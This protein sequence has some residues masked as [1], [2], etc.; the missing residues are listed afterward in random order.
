MSLFTKNLDKAIKIADTDKNEERWITVR[1]SH[2]KIDGQGNPIVGNSKL[3]AAIKGKRINGASEKGVSFENYN[4]E[5]GSILQEV[6]TL[7][8]EKGEVDKTKVEKIKKSLNSFLEKYNS[9]N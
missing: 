1:G 4:A 2:V 7:L 8:N 6:N 3:I 5:L 9:T